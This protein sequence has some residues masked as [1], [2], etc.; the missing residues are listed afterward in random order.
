MTDFAGF[1]T[2]LRSGGWEGLTS[3]LLIWLLFAFYYYFWRRASSD[4][5]REGGI[6]VLAAA[7]GAV[8]T[9]L[10]FVSTACLLFLPGR[11]LPL[12][13]G[14]LEGAAVAI[15]VLRRWLRRA[16]GQLQQTGRWTWARGGPRSPSLRAA[17]LLLG[18]MVLASFARLEKPFTDGL[19]VG[20]W[21]LYGGAMVGSGA[22][23]WAWAR[24][25]EL[26]GFK[27]LL[28]RLGRRPA[29]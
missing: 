22:Y 28:I 20:V 26:Q 21:S 19:V 14:F 25:K 16:D 6:R 18:L 9:G 7:R 11:W 27:P 10:V 4:L 12:A 29:T 3:L 23:C 8:L 24:R 5:E 17:W 15:L 1:P 2:W 13:R